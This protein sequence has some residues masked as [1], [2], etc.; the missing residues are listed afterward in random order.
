MKKCVKNRCAQSVL[1][2]GDNKT[3]EEAVDESTVDLEG[4]TAVVEIDGRLVKDMAT[5]IRHTHA[6]IYRHIQMT[7][8]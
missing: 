1:I 4:Q 3:C 8:D 7:S 6:Q 2:V 5:A